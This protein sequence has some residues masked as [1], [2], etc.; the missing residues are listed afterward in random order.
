[1]KKI[2]CL[3]YII[4]SPEPLLLS[5]QIFHRI[6]MKK[7]ILADNQDITKEGLI[8]LLNQL[9]LPVTIDIVVNTDELQKVLKEYP[10]AIVILDYT[11]FDFTSLYQMLNM[12]QRVNNSIW[13]LFSDELSV[14]FLRQI[15]FSD[16]AKNISIVMK[17]DSSKDIKTSLEQAFHNKTFLCNY[18]LQIIKEE[19]PQETALIKL[20]A[21]E[22]EIL[23][24]IALGKMTKQ[25][26]WERNLSFHT[27][28]THRKNIF[29]KL[30]INN[31]HEAIKYA[32]RAGII[33][34]TEY[35]I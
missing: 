25:I 5:Y 34:Q 21:T 3:W 19:I 35:Y 27:V 10:N 7:Y 24:E 15:F 31:V 33:D 2:T 16:E 26:A 12:K 14:H 18:V 28:N 1:M 4:I 32:L 6:L 29:R 13:I 22:K 8:Y 23:H 9:N 11:L 17:Q 30:E 20:T